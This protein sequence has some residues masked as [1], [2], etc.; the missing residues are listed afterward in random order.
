M[1]VFPNLH[2][3]VFE[4]ETQAMAL[5]K[6][7]LVMELSH[8]YGLYGSSQKPY[9]FTKSQLSIQSMFKLIISSYFANP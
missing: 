4:K 5:M 7:V 3:F 6:Y 1:I 9:M 8:P 2:L